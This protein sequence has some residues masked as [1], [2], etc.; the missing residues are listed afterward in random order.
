MILKVFPNDIIYQYNLN[1]KKRNGFIYL[2]IRRIVYGLPQ[3]WR[4]ENK[5]LKKNLAT[6]GYYEV[7]H[8]PGLWNNIYCTVTFS[9]AIDDFGIKYVDKE[10]ANQLL[11]SLKK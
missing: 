8:T 10:H 6:S 11:W 1:E 4:L 9:L 2:E 3:A 5:Y 7:P